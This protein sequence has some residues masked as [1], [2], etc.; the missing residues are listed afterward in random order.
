M[1]RK[2]ALRTRKFFNHIELIPEPE[3]RKCNL[4]NTP[5]QHGI[6][7]I[8]IRV[9]LKQFQANEFSSVQYWWNLP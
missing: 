2:P 3:R 8:F 5:Q 4:S 9:T 6:A 7:I 1:R